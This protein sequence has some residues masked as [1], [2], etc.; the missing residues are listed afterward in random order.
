M[1]QTGTRKKA[2][3]YVLF[4]KEES[5]ILYVLCWKPALHFSLTTGSLILCSFLQGAYIGLLENIS[6]SNKP[7]KGNF[8]SFFWLCPFPPTA[9]CVYV[10]FFPLYCLNSI[11]AWCTS[12]KEMLRLTGTLCMSACPPPASLRISNLCVTSTQTQNTGRRH[13]ST[14]FSTDS[15]AFL[16][17]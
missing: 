13:S 6:V 14:Q 3:L 10:R 2:Q 9:L 16:S 8:H 5:A 15:K 4:G 1:P 12:I 11:L 7:K 17:Y